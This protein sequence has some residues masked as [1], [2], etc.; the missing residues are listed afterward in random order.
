MITPHAEIAAREGKR[1][2]AKD[3]GLLSQ[4][5][6]FTLLYFVLSPFHLGYAQDLSSL[7]RSLAEIEREGDV[8]FSSPLRVGQIRG[9]E[10]I[11]GRIADGELFFQL[12]DPIR[13]AIVF[14]DIVEN[15]PNH[16]AYADAFFLLAESLFYAK[17][18]LGARAKYI[19]IFNQ[20]TDARFRSYILPSLARVF[21]I[22]S[23]TQNY[24]QMDEYAEKVKSYLGNDQDD[25]ICY[26]YAKYLYGAALRQNESSENALKQARDIFYQVSKK[27]DYYLQSR[28][29]VGVIETLL[30]NWEK[31]IAVFELVKNYEEE[32]NSSVREI[33]ELATLALGRIYYERE[34]LEKAIEAYEEIPESSNQFEK[35]LYEIAWVYIRKGDAIRAEQSLEMLSVLAPESLL[36]PDATLLRGNLLLRNGR[37]QDASQIF[38]SIKENYTPV[39]GELESIRKKHDN[40]QGYFKELIHSNFE[41]FDSHRFLPENAQRYFDGHGGSFDNAMIVLGSLS[42]L[43]DYMRETQDTVMSLDEALLSENPIGLFSDL[44]NQTRRIAMVRNR[45]TLLLR[46]VVEHLDINP[47]KLDGLQGVQLPTQDAQF[48]E[49]EGAEIKKYVELERELKNLNVE[50]VGMEAR[51]TATKRFVSEREVEGQ[52]KVLKELEAHKEALT[53]YREQAKELSR[54]VNIARIG[55]GIS[56]ETIGEGDRF[57][58]SYQDSIRGSRQ[59][60]QNASL[61]RIY[62]RVNSLEKKLEKREQEIEQIL[63]RRLSQIRQIVREEKSK[64]EG[65]QQ[66]LLRLQDHSEEVV[67]EVTLAYFDAAQGRFQE[68]I[69]RSDLGHIDIAWAKRE[70]HRL[71]VETLTQERAQEMQALDEEFR[72]ITN[73]GEQRK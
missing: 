49:R 58:R 55:V 3:C 32:I 12:G 6:F 24:E 66:A 4:L 70:K 26:F 34:Y 67:S 25:G 39:L 22:A 73:D 41:S 62:S 28:Y 31:A 16:S 8:I 35:A 7:E 14:T 9:S 37:F 23:I 36:A 18:H 60:G 53:E 20:N 68:I 65:Y 57:R 33:Q 5:V 1:V 69:R 40:L 27:G 10:Y 21:E 51:I 11:E 59:L 56:E 63:E 64:L 54:S 2:R 52:Q 48:Q 46:E 29:F 61:Q 38:N 17:D 45:L 15:Y 72:E 47:S 30:K 13:A 44:S 42:Q 50:L 71:R 43:S 19:E